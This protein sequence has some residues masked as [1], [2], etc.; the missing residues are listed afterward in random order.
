MPK[1]Y[2]KPNRYTTEFWKLFL[3]TRIHLKPLPFHLLA[4]SFFQV[5]KVKYLELSLNLSFLSQHIQP[6]SKLF[7]LSLKHMEEHR[8]FLTISTPPMWEPVGFSAWV[9]AIF[10][11]LPC[12]HPQTTLKREG[13]VKSLGKFLLNYNIYLYTFQKINTSM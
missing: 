13:I 12:P 3:R 7:T 8:L 11:F 6:I 10:S 4:T 2:P 9:P 5:L 1:S